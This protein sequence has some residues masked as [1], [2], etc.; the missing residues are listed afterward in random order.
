MYVLNG[1]WGEFYRVYLQVAIARQ[2]FL[3]WP[4]SENGCQAHESVCA[5]T[6][7]DVTTNNNY[8]IT[9]FGKPFWQNHSR[10]FSAVHQSSVV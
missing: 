7:N 6:G 4:S 5:V 8:F 2:N 10:I 3:L 1:L 9:Q